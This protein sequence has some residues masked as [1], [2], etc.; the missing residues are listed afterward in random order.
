MTLASILVATDF[1]ATADTAVDRAADLAKARGA[2]LVLFHAVAVEP[3]PVA[4]AGFE[5]L[6]P[7]FQERVREASAQRLDEAVAALVARGIDAV[8][9]LELAPPGSAV[10]SAAERMGV[11]LIVIGTRG[12][13]GFEHLLL[14]STAE[15]VLRSAA[16]PVLVVHPGDGRPL[17][18]IRTLVVAVD[19]SEESRRALTVA[20]SLFADFE[21]RPRVVL[22]HA[23]HLPVALTPLAGAYPVGSIAVDEACDRARENL[24]EDAAPLRDE[25]FEVEAVVTQGD[26]PTSI[27]EYAA[28]HGADVVVL[29]THGYSGLK[30]MLL[31]S[32][33]ERVLKHAPCPVLT[34]RRAEP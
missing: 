25:G 29:G 6:P 31:G 22:L 5:V 12:L 18:P 15:Q 33:A 10:P 9:R 32:T 2:R 20:A 26:P 4:G 17:D 7:D 21:P 8:G 16:C 30:H 11:D 19:F 27:A 1:S 13:A 34:L 24:Q 14:G 3:M 23:F 28:A